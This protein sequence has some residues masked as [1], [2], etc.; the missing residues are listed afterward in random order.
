[1]KKLFALIAGVAICYVTNA[2]SV[3]WSVNAIQSS[4]DITVGAGWLV[5]VYSSTVTF[6]PQKASNGELTVWSSSTS[7]SA[8]LTYRATATVADGLSKGTSAGFYAVIWDA[9]SISNAKN[10]IVSDIYTATAAI[11]DQPVNMS[12]GSMAASTTANKFLNSQ[13]QSIPEPTSG[14]LLLL[15]AAGLALK[16]KHV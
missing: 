4:P 8:G 14:L 6:N 13:W 16:R 10:Y 9:D 15:G 7:I 2:A 3:T 1:M 12:F 5:Q 11:T